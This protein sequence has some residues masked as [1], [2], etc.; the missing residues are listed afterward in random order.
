M[1]T[2]NDYI[3]LSEVLA[4]EGKNSAEQ[5]VGP[6]SLPNKTPKADSYLFMSSCNSVMAG[7]EVEHKGL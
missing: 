6:L 4:N 7:Q 2:H 3:A 5:V 1:S